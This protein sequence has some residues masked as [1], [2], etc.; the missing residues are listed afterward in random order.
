MIGKRVHCAFIV[1]AAGMLAS[2]APARSQSDAVAEFYRGKAITMVV[3]FDPGGMYGLYSRLIAEHIGK[4]IPGNPAIVANHMPGAGGVRAGNYMFNVAAKDGIAIA[5]LSKDT[6]VAQRLQPDGVKYDAARFGW[7]GSV[8]PYTATFMVWHTADVKNFAEARQKELIVGS[9]GR[10]SHEYSEAR[11]LAALAG[12]KLRLVAGYKGAADMY[13]AMER[14]EID[15]RI[16]A[17]A[18]LKATRPDW[19]RDGKVFNILQTGI[20]RQ[21]DLPNVPRLIDVV[22]A[23]EEKEMFEFMAL[24]GPVGWSIATP[25]DVPADRLAALR[26]AFEAMIKDAEFV[27]DVTKRGAEVQP[28][29]GAQVAAAIVR[30]LAISPDVIARMQ[31]V[32]AE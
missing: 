15:A 20:D 29:T 19:L 23:R 21:P 4:F 12:M 24:G 2:A 26:R 32:V 7:V 17:W 9:T 11:L 30:T 27:A 10:G 22:Q 6:A 14:G 1:V 25:P 16:G 31:K 3:A 13:L 8:F 18:S 28:R 5:M